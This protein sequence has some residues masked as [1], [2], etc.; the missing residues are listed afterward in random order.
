MFCHLS[1]K[2]EVFGHLSLFGLPSAFELTPMMNA[3]LRWFPAIKG[4]RFLAGWV[5]QG[6]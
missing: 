2:G 6:A 5:F 4:L 1:E 3:R